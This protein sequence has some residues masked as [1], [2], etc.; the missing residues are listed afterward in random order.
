MGVGALAQH[1][2]QGQKVQRMGEA[3]HHGPGQLH[4]VQ[5][6]HRVGQAGWST[7]GALWPLAVR[8]SRQGGDAGP[9]Q[10]CL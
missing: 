8:A 1:A 3:G 5:R 2:A 6:L 4:W 10:L 9:A 7:G